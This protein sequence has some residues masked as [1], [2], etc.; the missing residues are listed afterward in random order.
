MS[1]RRSLLGVAA[2]A[3][4]LLAA[5]SSDESTRTTPTTASTAATTSGGQAAPAKTTCNGLT[6]AQTEGPFFKSNTP[7]KT[8]LT[9]DVG[10][11][12]RVVVTGSV[13]TGSC[14]PV[15]RARIE[16]WQADAGGEYDNSGYRLRGHLFSDA[17]G[18]Y[19]FETIEP[20]AYSGRTRH[21]HVKVQ[22][23]E[24][25]VLTTQLYFPGE[26]GNAQDSIF[27]PELVMAVKSVG[28]GKEAVFDFVV[29]T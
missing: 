28:S 22:P 16:V 18:H 6:P 26:S 25:P 4:I 11:G 27:Q 15:G 7:E 8:N 19:R 23:P 3:L 12:T 20:G 10:T 21:I 9:A 24:G 14:A 17:D 13:L 2:A 29:R 5:C 1:S